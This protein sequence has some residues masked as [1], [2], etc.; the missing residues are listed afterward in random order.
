MGTSSAELL[1]SGLAVML[2]KLGIESAF[3]LR[4]SMG[5]LTLI[6]DL[7]FHDMRDIFIVSPSHSAVN[8]EAT[9]LW[10]KITATAL[11][12]RMDCIPFV[13]VIMFSK[14]FLK[15]HTEVPEEV[16]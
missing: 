12:R 5:G 16:D 4:H 3:I 2:K 13:P 9:K 14:G 8:T 6:A 11:M 7:D 1:A 10:E 15:S